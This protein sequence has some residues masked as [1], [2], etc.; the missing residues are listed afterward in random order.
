VRVRR[1]VSTNWIRHPSVID[2]YNL[3]IHLIPNVES[4]IIILIFRNCR[5][6]RQTT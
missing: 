2:D 4:N 3:G 1:S 6:E 5:T